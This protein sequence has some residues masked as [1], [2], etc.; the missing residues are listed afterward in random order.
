MKSFLVLSSKRANFLRHFLLNSSQSICYSKIIFSPVFYYS[1]QFFFSYSFIFLQIMVDLFNTGTVQQ[2]MYTLFSNMYDKEIL[3][4]ELDLEMLL[5]HPE[6][7]F[8]KTN[9]QLT[10]SSWS[11]MHILFF[12][13]ELFCVSC[14]LLPPISCKS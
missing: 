5:N 12:L 9:F 7:F 11:S 13:Q 8:K 6:L 1:E 10:A 2:C 4:F 14:F 3:L